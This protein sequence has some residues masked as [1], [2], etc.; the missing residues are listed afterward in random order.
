MDEI[1]Q[2]TDEKDDDDRF[3]LESILEFKKFDR[4]Q[5]ENVKNNQE[6]TDLDE[7]STLEK[8]MSL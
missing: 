3:R 1:I 4:F 6:N 7:V 8:V 5:G 2:E